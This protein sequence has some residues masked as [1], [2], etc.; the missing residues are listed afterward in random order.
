MTAILYII[1]GVLFGALVLLAATTSPRTTVSLYELRRRKEARDKDATRALRREEILS[2]LGTLK[3]PLSALI[4][5]ALLFALVH[6]FGRSAGLI[7][8][9]VLVLLYNRLAQIR[10]VRK[11]ASA[12]Y[13]RYETKLLLIAEKYE[14]ILRLISG[15]QTLRD[16]RVSLASREELTHILEASDIFTNE[17]RVLLEHALRFK[18]QK[19]KQLMV[20]RDE[21]VTVPATE[22]LGPLVLDDLHKTGHTVFP[23]TK[24]KDI[25]GLLDSSDHVA[26]RSKESVHVRSVMHTD[27][28]KIDQ[29]THLNEVLQV[30]IETKQSLLIVVDDD[31]QVAGL[32][33]LGDVVRALT[34]WKQQ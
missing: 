1:S 4:L 8:T 7:I 22:L 9:V 32:I 28:T 10:M 31:N 27:I 21:M 18:E 33:S 19:V 25:V 29:S 20:P 16:M 23:V 11:F 30:F 17:D 14:S 15:K 6:L 3:A 34:G 24:G 26:L 5:I 13:R 2:Q 12:Q